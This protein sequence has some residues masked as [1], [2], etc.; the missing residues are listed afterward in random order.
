MQPLLQCVEIGDEARHIQLGD[1]GGTHQGEFTVA[2][3]RRGQGGANAR[4]LQQPA[5]LQSD[6]DGIRVNA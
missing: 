3:Q 2:E 5:L 6:Q 4:G 1:M